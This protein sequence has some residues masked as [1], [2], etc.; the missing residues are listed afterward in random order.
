MKKEVFNLNFKEAINFGTEMLSKREE[1]SA[2]FDARELLSFVTGKTKTEVSFSLLESLTKKEEEKYKA[3]L[4]KR[5]GGYP[6]Q[7]ILGEWEFYGID[8]KVGEGVLIPRADTETLVDCVLNL[9]LVKN[10]KDLKL[11][12]L[13]AGS[14][15]IA[16][17]LKSCGNF[18][19]VD[20]VEISKDAF[21]YL[22][23]NTK[24][25]GVNAIL[26]DALT[27]SPK[28]KYHIITSN[29]PYITFEERKELS[30]EIDFEPETALTA[31][32]DGLYFYKRFAKR[33]KEFLL[34]GG[35]I[36][37]EIGSKQKEAVMQI[38][39]ENGYKDIFSAS[40]LCGNERV[41]GGRK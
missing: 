8:F 27:F 26:D 23:E 15:A 33:Y 25:R 35:Y 34:D 5:L 16:V 36:V 40:D 32:E 31:P 13:C 7:Y 11:L 17:A 3:L 1:I 9:P 29:P 38:L 10:G 22:L 12:D 30:M 6:L 14:G 21:V 28:G 2:N 4:E 41:V 20:A 37:F 18:Q 19:K 24:D 39:L